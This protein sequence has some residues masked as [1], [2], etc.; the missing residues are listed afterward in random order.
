[1]EKKVKYGWH[2]K[3]MEEYGGTIFWRTPDGGEVEVTAYTDSKTLPDSYKWDDM[4]L[5]GEVTEFLRRGK[6]PV[7]MRQ[8]MGGLNDGK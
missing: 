6:K 4:K 3:K 5:V 1:M 2:S 7:P 8:R